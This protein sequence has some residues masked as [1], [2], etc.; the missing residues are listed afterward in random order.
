MTRFD[1]KKLTK[2]ERLLATAPISPMS[3]RCPDCGGYVKPICRLQGRTIM[4]LHRDRN[5]EQTLREAT[6]RVC[7]SCCKADREVWLVTLP[8]GRL[9]AVA[10]ES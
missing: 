8:S 10:L 9:A 6:V 1:W 4:E 5:F 3:L 7:T 2:R